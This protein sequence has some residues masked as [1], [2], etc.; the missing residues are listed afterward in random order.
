MQPFETLNVSVEI[1]YPRKLRS[2]CDKRWFGS[3]RQLSRVLDQACDE[4]YGD[5][6]GVREEGSL[7]AK[8]RNDNRC[9][10]AGQRRCI[11]QRIPAL[12]SAK[13]TSKT[14]A[15][16]LTY[17]YTVSSSRDI[18]MLTFRCQTPQSHVDPHCE[19]GH[20]MACRPSKH[21]ELPTPI[22]SPSP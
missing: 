1:R 11:A 13:S 22:L 3:V 9:Y 5:L 14:I 16:I 8:Q 4:V 12:Q 18:A 17:S 21:A 2:V 7:L 15:V 10:C 20:R 19:Q 6:L